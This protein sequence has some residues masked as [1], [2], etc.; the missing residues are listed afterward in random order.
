M[1]H[2]KLKKILPYIVL[3]LVMFS[4]G[5]T[6]SALALTASQEASIRQQQKEQQA[7]EDAANYANSHNVEADAT[8]A[9]IQRKKDQAYAEAYARNNNVEDPG[10]LSPVDNGENLPVL[11][12]AEFDATIAKVQ[13]A[14]TSQARMYAEGKETEADKRGGIVKSTAGVIGC[15]GANLL[16]TIISSTI[17]N[18]ISQ[19]I[20]A[21]FNFLSGI[22]V[23]EKGEVG[24]NIRT[25]TQAK[26]GTVVGGS[27]VGFGGAAI[28]F[29]SWDSIMYCITNEIINYIADSTIAWVRGGFEGNPAFIDNPG[30]FFKDLAN[31]EASSFLQGL[32]YGAVGLNICEPFRAQLVLTIARS[33]L[34]DQ[35]A[36]GGTGGYSQGGF[37]GGQVVGPNGAPSRGYVGTTADGKPITMSG[38]IGAGTQ[39]QYGGGYN[40]YGGCSLDDIE[41][42]F[43]GFINGNFAKGGWNSWFKVTQ[44]ESNNPYSAYFNLEAQLSG[45]IN[46]KATVVQTELNWGR[47]FLS[48]KKCEEAVEEK[49]K[50]NCK[51][52]TPGTLIEGQLEKTLGIAKDRLVLA[53]RFDQV[54][55]VVVDQLINTALDKVFEVLTE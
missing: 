55:A 44:V 32:A 11:A 51:I 52:T 3:L 53:E 41:G 28:V 5:V 31:L 30:Q 2:H 26:T 50:V 36:Y 46:K 23:S 33:H 16:A 25:Q 37:N 54:I 12:A 48:F 38:Y 15:T 7:R 21:F 10:G 9:E 35:Y 20:N 43:K 34:A 19:N 4:F 39:G 8:P 1:I 27:F 13:A 45:A 47:G 29:P 24:A 18:Y 6:K 14:T 49:D 42:N 22:P 17:H 40:N